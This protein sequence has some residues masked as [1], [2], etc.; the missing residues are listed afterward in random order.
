MKALKLGIIVVIVAVVGFVVYKIATPSKSDSDEK[1]ISIEK[2]DIKEEIYIPGNVYPVKEIEIKPQ[3]SGILSEIFVKIGD[4]VEKGTPIASVGLVPSAIELERL[5]NNVRLAKINFDAVKLSYERSEK[6]FETNTISKSEM[7]EAKKNYDTAKEQLVSVQ[8]QLDIQKKGRVSSSSQISNIVKSSIEGTVIDLPLES[9]ASVVERNSLNPGTT[10]AVLAQMGQ[11]VFRTQVAEQYLEHIQIGDTILL[12]F[13]AY[14]NLKTIAVV[15]K[16]SAKGVL[17]NGIMKYTLD[18]EFPVDNQMPTI[19]SGYSATAEIILNSK[20]QVLSI[21]EKYIIYRNDSTFVIVKDAKG[22][23]RK[24]I[25]LGVS[26]G[27]FTEI[28]QGISESDK[29]VFPTAEDLLSTPDKA[30]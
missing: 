7:E 29:I 19:R 3:L 5:E 22:K 2:R 28:T 20:K 12:S 9:G 1:T 11:F 27:Q 15:N 18:A 26:N 6:L 21:P 30:N 16:I 23:N 4:R 10:V 24:S 17:E 13:N 25:S 8:N 14:K